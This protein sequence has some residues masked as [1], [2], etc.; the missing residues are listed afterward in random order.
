[1]SPGLFM[2]PPHWII[3]EERKRRQER[4]R[5]WEP[6]PLHAPSPLPPDRRDRPTEE[7]EEESRNVIIIDLNDYTEIPL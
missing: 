7:A 4:E 1:M 5:R 2:L 6:V 3:E